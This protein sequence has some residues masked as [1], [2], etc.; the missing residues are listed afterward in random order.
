M[1]PEFAAEPLGLRRPGSCA[2]CGVGMSIREL[3]QR[4]SEVVFP[5]GHQLGFCS[6]LFGFF[7]LF[8][9]IYA[10]TFQF[11][12]GHLPGPPSEKERGVSIRTLP[13]EQLW[14]FSSFGFWVPWRTVASLD[15]GQTGRGDR[16]ALDQGLCL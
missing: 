15:T 7:I 16:E 13:A 5:V 6:G 1:R 10:M 8:G 14:D 11:F 2:G 4:W 3:V 12:P 9:F